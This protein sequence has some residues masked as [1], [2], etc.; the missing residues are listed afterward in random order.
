MSSLIYEFTEF[1]GSGRGIM[2]L[3]LLP[4][5]VIAY[6]SDIEAIGYAI[7]D[8]TAGGPP[9]SGAIDPNFT[10]F[11]TPIKWAQSMKG[12]TFNWP[13]P[14]T[15]WP[16]PNKRYRIVV[17]FTIIDPHPDLYLSGKS[18]ILAWEV[19]TKSPTT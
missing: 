7:Y 5:N 10:M 13:A 11:D 9:V 2:A 15:L 3:P 12:A 16:L 19:I 6:K 18:F 1:A 14:G 4:N 8:L 17:T